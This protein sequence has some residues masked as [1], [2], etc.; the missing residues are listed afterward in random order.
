MSKLKRVMITAK[1]A[2]HPSGSGHTLLGLGLTSV[3]LV[4]ANNAV[5]WPLQ[6]PNYPTDILANPQRSW[7]RHHTNDHAGAWGF[8]YEPPL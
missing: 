3:T 5:L 1:K 8:P 4:A 7:I 6:I 2:K